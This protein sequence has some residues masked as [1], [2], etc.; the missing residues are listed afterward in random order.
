[1]NREHTTSANQDTPDDHLAEMSCENNS[2]NSFHSD[3]SQVDKSEDHDSLEEDDSD[4]QSQ[5]SGLDSVDDDTSCDLGDESQE[6]IGQLVRVF[7]LL[8]MCPIE[9]G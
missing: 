3:H 2:T 5:N 8:K 6:C 4:A 7:C 9:H 1:M